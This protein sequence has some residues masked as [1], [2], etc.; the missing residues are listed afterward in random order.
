MTAE[1]AKQLRRETKQEDY[2]EDSIEGE[3]D[4]Y[5]VVDNIIRQKPVRALTRL[6]R[7][8]AR[9]KVPAFPQHSNFKSAVETVDMLAYVFCPLLASMR[10]E[11]DSVPAMPKPALRSLEKLFEALSRLRA[12]L[13]RC[14]LGS[15]IAALLLSDAIALEFC[16]LAEE[17]HDRLGVFPWDLFRAARERPELRT[18]VDFVVEKTAAQRVHIDRADM[19][20]RGVIEGVVT[21]SGFFPD[22]ACVGKLLERL[23]LVSVEDQV[24]EMMQLEAEVRTRREL[25]CRRAGLEELVFYCKHVFLGEFWPEGPAIYLRNP[26][27]DWVIPARF[28]CPLSK[29]VMRD[30]VTVSSGQTFER[31]NIERWF[32]AGHRLCPITHRR[33][34][35][36]ATAL[37]ATNLAVQRQIRTWLEENRISLRVSEDEGGTKAAA[38]YVVDRLSQ[39]EAHTTEIAQQV[40]RRLTPRLR[41]DAKLATEMGEAGLIKVL[42][43]MLAAED[44]N[45]RA[46]SVGAVHAMAAVG[47]NKERIMEE[48]NGA[49]VNAIIDMVSEGSSWEARGSAAGTLYRLSTVRA[50]R[51]CLA[52]EVRVVEGLKRLAREAEPASV[53]GEAL[54]ALLA[55]GGERVQLEEM[56][57]LLRL[58]RKGDVEDVVR[59]LAVD[60]VLWQIKGIRDGATAWKKRQMRRAA[61]ALLEA[62]TEW[63]WRRGPFAGQPEKE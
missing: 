5:V 19:E 2:N 26:V 42:L 47:G 48:G 36:G 16:D 63:V 58:C 22:E 32:R 62:C 28:R 7:R 40:I 23:G 50:Y 14:A 9:C 45:L 31:A 60:P 39:F 25:L 24:N 27:V 29:A 6:A 33:L 46:S 11:E 44:A 59:V 53:R 20:L 41:A 18:L 61:A 52:R 54:A 51:W 57:R 37:P 56:T 13:E 38:G 8:T 21:P 3:E 15:K 55:Q 12:L 35:G 4:D 30:P 49:G 17:L 34:N 1:L 10:P 43:H